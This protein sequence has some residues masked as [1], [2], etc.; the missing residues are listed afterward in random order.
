[1]HRRA[2]DEC[3]VA[4][5]WHE[6]ADLKKM[7]FRL[8][9]VL[10]NVWS[11]RHFRIALANPIESQAWAAIRTFPKKSQNVPLEKDVTWNRMAPSCPIC[12]RGRRSKR[13]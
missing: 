8:P 10:M 1:M 5:K 6:M 4:Q 13:G 11:F 2:I 9:L 3:K 7:L 12:F